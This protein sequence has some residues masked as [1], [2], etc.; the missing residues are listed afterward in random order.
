MSTSG[1]LQRHNVTTLFFTR[2]SSP[3]VGTRSHLPRPTGA[4]PLVPSTDLRHVVRSGLTTCN[5]TNDIYTRVSWVSISTETFESGVYRTP[6]TRDS[7]V[8]IGNDRRVPGIRTTEC[9]TGRG[10][11][12]RLPKGNIIPFWSQGL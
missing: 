9:C 2:V 10:D 11:P 3:T 8:L 1:T 6:V 5:L 7:K 12:G 4:L